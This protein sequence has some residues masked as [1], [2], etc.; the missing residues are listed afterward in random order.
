MFRQAIRDSPRR[1]LIPMDPLTT[2]KGYTLT[3]GQAARREALL[4]HVEFGSNYV[5]AVHDNLGRM[6]WSET[7]DQVDLWLTRAEACVPGAP[8]ISAVIPTVEPA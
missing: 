7:H 2:H 1:T 8:E 3:A 4:P 6:A 5:R